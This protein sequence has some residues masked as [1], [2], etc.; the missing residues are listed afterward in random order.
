MTSTAPAA[1]APEFANWIV[2]LSRNTLLT[3]V[4]PI[5]TVAPAW[6]CMPVIVP[7]A[8][9]VETTFGETSLIVG[10]GPV[11]CV[12]GSLAGDFCATG[13]GA[14]DGAAGE[15]HADAKTAMP[16]RIESHLTARHTLR[17][18]LRE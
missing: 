11:G 14:I 15:L 13:L 3:T 16:T 9:A 18:V 8:P 17:S 1:W 5:L 7:Q 6:N 10:W 12:T 2:A 4:F